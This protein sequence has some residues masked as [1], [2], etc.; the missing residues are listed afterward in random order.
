MNIHIRHGYRCWLSV[1]VRI[2]VQ[3]LNMG[4]NVGYGYRWWIWVQLLGMGTRVGYG[5]S[6]ECGYKFWVWVQ[7]LSMDTDIGY[8]DI[9]LGMG[10]GTG[11]E[12]RCCMCTGDG[13]WYRY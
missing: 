5:T 10:T 4:T 13:N 8:G 6:I 2:W 11:N 12:Y 3:V 7:V 1:K 9:V